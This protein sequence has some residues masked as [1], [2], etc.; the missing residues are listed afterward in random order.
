MPWDVWQERTGQGRLQKTS[1]TR[2]RAS[3]LRAGHS[4]RPAGRDCRAWKPGLAFSPP[5][6][7]PSPGDP[8]AHSGRLVLQRTPWQGLDETP[9]ALPSAHVDPLVPG[10]TA[11]DAD[12]QQRRQ[13]DR[14]GQRQSWHRRQFRGELIGGRAR[15]ARA[16]LG[17]PRRDV[18]R[19]GARSGWSDRCGIPRAVPFTFSPSP[20]LPRPT[21]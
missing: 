21:R 6:A 15:I 2:S 10:P 20:L 13:R 19:Y 5:P 17:R 14:A 11:Y 8:V 16:V 18:D 7:S 9:H 12:K 1:A 4:R 3:R